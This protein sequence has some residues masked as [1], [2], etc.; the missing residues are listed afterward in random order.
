MRE[1]V[2]NLC[3]IAAGLPQHYNIASRHVQPQVGGSGDD[4]Y[5]NMLKS[6]WP[7]FEA[8]MHPEGVAQRPEEVRQRPLSRELSQR[9]I[10]W[11][12]RTLLAPT[13]PVSSPV[14]QSRTAASRLCV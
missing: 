14:Q 11:Y 1:R 7:S 4:M 9:L 3:V 6:W 10:R 12:L 13:S 5:T 2:Q 8:S